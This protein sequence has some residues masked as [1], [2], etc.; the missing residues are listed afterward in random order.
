MGQLCEGLV[1]DQSCMEKM[2]VSDETDRK[3]RLSKSGSGQRQ[4]VGPLSNLRQ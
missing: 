4:E 1:H 3:R 2:L